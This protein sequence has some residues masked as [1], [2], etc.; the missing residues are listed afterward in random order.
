LAKKK[1]IKAE[2]TTSD[3]NFFNKVKTGNEVADSGVRV[4]TIDYIDTGCYALNA[5][6]SG[7]IY[8]G[9]PSNRVSMLA[10]EEAVGK[11]FFT[12]FGHCRPL[13]EKGY[14]IYYI[15]TEGA[16]DEPMLESYGLEEGQFQILP[17]STV[18]KVRKTV[19]GILD[20]IEAY[21][22]SNK[23]RLKVAFMMDSLGNLATEKSIEDT[24]KGKDT[25][26][27]TKQQAL[28]R[29]F[30]ELVTR[31]GIMNIPWV[32]TNHVYEK[33]GSYIS[34]KQVAGGSGA[35]YNSSVILTLRKRK[36]KDENKVRTG[37]IVIANTSKSRYVKEDCEAQFY[38]DFKT[39]LN[40][41]WGLHLIAIEAGLMIPWEKS[42]HGPDSDTP[43]DRPP[44]LHHSSKVWILKESDDP[45]TWSTIAEKDSKTLHSKA[46]IGRIMPAI[47]AWVNE[48]YKYSKPILAMNEDELEVPD[49]DLDE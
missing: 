12:V 47:N 38:L 5:I 23:T 3:F 8:K 33:V 46:G 42:S 30:S 25:R 10:G 6:Y 28:K 39:G 36:E 29:M 11:T 16:V 4:E 18:E 31:M 2:E 48:N 32:I 13:A 9:F 44:G 27:M 43:I 49:I 26:D 19:S 20:Q 1:S 21:N 22:K 17:T 14:F 40:R 45:A 24:S 34:G 37:T 35:L 41:Y 7:D 15:D